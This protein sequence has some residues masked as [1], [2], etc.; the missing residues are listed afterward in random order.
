MVVMCV[1]P[2][3]QHAKN[4]ESG[5]CARTLINSGKAVAL[6]FYIAGRPK[7]KMKRFSLYILLPLL[8]LLT[9]ASSTPSVDFSKGRHFNVCKDL[10]SD[11]L[12]YFVFVDTRSTHPW[13]E[14]DIS[15]TID[16][17]HVASRW[18]EHEARERGLPLQ[19]KT[20]YYIGDEF[21]TVERNLPAKSI[22][23]L[24]EN[25]GLFD[26]MRSLSRWGDMIARTIGESLYLKEKDGIPSRKQPVSKERLIAFLRDEYQVESVILLMMVNNYFKSDISLAI[27][28]L[29]NEDVEFAL[30]S[31]KY[32]SEIAHSILHLYGAA[33]L[34]ASPFRRSGAKIKHASRHF[35]DDIMGDVYARPLVELE[36]GAF[37]DYMIGWKQ[38]LNRDY[39]SLLT[40][41][42][43]LFK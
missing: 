2:G 33:D 6:F 35:P 43:T 14:F 41:R 1:R 27:N 19:I 16:S 5:T 10:K 21:T 4:V 20:D 3:N 38:E 15:S 11:V 39:E 26:G 12:V 32:P 22:K 24:I 7:D 31:Y 37:T 36:I 8:L 28:T 40:E 29:T 18:L 23:E 34:Q 30:V 25:R 42:F 17:I 9:G 13:T